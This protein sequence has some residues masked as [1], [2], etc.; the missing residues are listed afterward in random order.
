M[1]YE[2]DLKASPV[3]VLGQVEAGTRGWRMALPKEGDEAHLEADHRV[4]RLAWVV[5]VEMGRAAA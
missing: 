5:E 4:V 3:L 1:G 2:V